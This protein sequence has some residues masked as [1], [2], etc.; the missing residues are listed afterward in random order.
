MKEEQNV[1]NKV[2]KGVKSLKS[3]MRW[4][5]QKQETKNPQKPEPRKVPL[6][7][8]VMVIILLQCLGLFLILN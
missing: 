5:E 1:V 8:A 2:K 4:P 6:P 7:A 3:G